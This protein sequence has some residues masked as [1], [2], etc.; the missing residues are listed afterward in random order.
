MIVIILLV[1]ATLGVQGL[2][3]SKLVVRK[4]FDWA[5]LWGLLGLGAGTLCHHESVLIDL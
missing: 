4:G 3:E 5:F 1:G 2:A